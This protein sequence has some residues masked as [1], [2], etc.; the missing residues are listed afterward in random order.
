MNVADGTDPDAH[1][2]TFRDRPFD[3]ASCRAAVKELA[4]SQQP[5]RVVKLAQDFIGSQQNDYV[6]AWG[7]N[8]LELVPRDS[9]LKFLT[10]FIESDRDPKVRRRAKYSRMYALK[11]LNALATKKADRDR[12]EALLEARWSDEKEDALPRAFAAAL[13]TKLGRREAREQLEAMFEEAD[14]RYWFPFM[15]I[16]ALRE[17]PVP[18]ALPHLVKILRDDTGYIEIRHRAIAVTARLEATRESVRAVGEVLE[19]DPNEYL[20]Q[21]AAVTL[22]ELGDPAAREDLIKGVTDTNAEVRVRA[23]RA[24]ERCS[25][26][27]AAVAALV[28]AA[29]ASENGK[30][31]LTGYVDALRVV[32]PERTRAT[33]ALS[34]ELG[35]EDRAHAERAESVLLELGGWSAVQRLSQRRATLNQLDQLLEASEAVVQETFKDTIK[36]AQ[37]NFYFALGVNALV[38]VLGVALSVIAVLHLIDQPENLEAW[39][40]PGAAGVLGILVN[41]LFNNPRTN[42]RNDL[43][44]LVNV[45]V[46]FL[47]FLRQLNEI[48]AT[49]KHA[50]IEGRDFGAD[51]MQRTVR[52]I[53]Q[54]VGRTL[55]LTGAHLSAAATPNGGGA[56]A[57]DP[58]EARN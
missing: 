32:D 9:S 20:R 18:A 7:I 31:E 6:R 13:G 26:R 54:T 51:D 11:A 22:G 58:A 53:E 47:G 28:S 15:I 1:F 56:L 12:F 50:Y 8:V 16:R 23:A 49:F 36:Q 10:G 29:V 55:E 52:R 4:G 57:E 37:R 17:C 40:L 43:A 24:L 34:K 19:C 5:D 42:A 3:L 48:D 33:E 2:D 35:A 38:V 46:L 44:T 14:Q 45:N 25:G 27:D 39:L 21:A 41:L 30:G